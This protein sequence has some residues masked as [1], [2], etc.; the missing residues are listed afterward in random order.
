MI[1]FERRKADILKK[2][3]KSSI[4]GIDKRIEK[5][6]SK[7]NKNPN[8]YTLS[9]CSGRIVLVKN[10]DK[11][12]AG[13]FSF[14]S[15]EKISFEE[16]KKVLS[17]AGEKKETLIFKQ[18]PPILALCCKTL[19]DASFMLD[20]AREKAGWKNSGIMSLSGRINLELRCTDYI[21]FPIMKDGVLLVGEDFLKILVEESN[22]RLEKGWGKIA[23]LEGEF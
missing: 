2:E 4:G 11:K 14:R 17:V 13:M 3:D 9:S 16:L 5:L 8:F 15:H 22:L 7:I 1:T 18:E 6:C 10:Q 20:K 19:E 12:E 23:R 21:S